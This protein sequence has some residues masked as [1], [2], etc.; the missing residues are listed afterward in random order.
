MNGLK[1]LNTDNLSLSKISVEVKVFDKELRSLAKSM[2]LYGESVD[3]CVGLA[4]AQV[5]K[6][7]K[8]CV[9]YINDRWRVVVNPKIIF[10]S[11]VQSVEYEGCMSLKEGNLF[12]EV[13]RPSRVLAEYYN[14]YGKRRMLRFDGFYAHL[15]QHEVDH[16]N[17]IIFTQRME[18][19]KELYTDKQLEQVLEKPFKDNVSKK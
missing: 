7:I 15:I 13:K 16:M 10:K 14:E 18:N 11:N 8:L 5:G 12:G 17:G 4:A 6:N 9:I 2:I 19:S 3:N 1:I